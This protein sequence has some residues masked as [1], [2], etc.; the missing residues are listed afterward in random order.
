MEHI[1]N[2]GLFDLG[3]EMVATYY[4]LSERELDVV[5]LKIQG[6]SNKDIADNLFLALATVK[7]YVGQIYQ[8]LHVN[9]VRELKKK[10]EDL[11]LLNTE[12][13]VHTIPS[14]IPTHLTSFLGRETEIATV[15]EL[16]KEHRLVTLTGVGGT[17]KTRLVL[18]IAELVR[19]Q[20]R[21]DIAFV[22]LT[23]IHSHLDVP[24]AIADTLGLQSQDNDVEHTIITALSNRHMLL[25]LDNFEHV[26]AS[27]LL[28]S[29]LLQG[30]PRLS[31]LVTS[32][33]VL[34]LA[35]ECEYSVSPL[36]LP[37]LESPNRDNPTMELFE[38]RA[39]L[40]SNR[41]E[42]TEDNLST[43][44]EICHRLDGLPL[45]IELAAT[46][47]K[48][49]TPSVL[50][51]RLDNRLALL[52]DGNRD[53]SRRQQ[54]IR[55]SIEWS[56]DLLN[57]E[58]KKLFARLSVFRGGR[59]LDACE[60]VCADGLDI[61]VLSGIASLVDKSLLQQQTDALGEPRFIMLETIHEFASECLKNSDEAYNI[62]LRHAEYFRDVAL[63]ADPELRHA[64][65]VTWFARLE[66]EI[67]NFRKALE[68]CHENSEGIL[69]VILANG[70]QY[71]WTKRIYQ[72]EC[73]YRLQQSLKYLDDVPAQ[74]Q[75]KLLIG[76]GEMEGWLRLD[77][78][79]GRILAEQALNIAHELGDNYHLGLA[80]L[81]MVTTVHGI[82]RELE[83][84]IMPEETMTYCQNAMKIFVELNTLDKLA[85]AYN[86]LSNLYG[87]LGDKDKE[88]ESIEKCI[89]IAKRAGDLRRVY[90]N[91]NNL[92]DYHYQAGNYAVAKEISREATIL[93]RDA[94]DRFVLT[95]IAWNIFNLEAE[96]I[97]VTR[98]IAHV[99]TQFERLGTRGEPASDLEFYR[100]VEYLRSTVDK[101][102]FQ[103]AWDEGSQLTNDDAIAYA[104]GEIDPFND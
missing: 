63:Y 5:R 67:N 91:L 34:R 1:T 84:E 44:A 19:D 83:S 64:Q 92:A 61:D 62:H 6:V 47:L 33:E 23:Q 4:D 95:Y 25:I 104:L 79:K 35:G 36:P 42:L 27:A 81:G 28:V 69:L 80:Y 38:S 54:T 29:T 96:P 60:V 68:W 103:K 52:T 59:S 90:V 3:Y 14:T 99:K 16:T 32:R 57:V 66:I 58:E 49:L 50:L 86:M 76:V 94:N 17:G 97:P 87:R 74:E 100:R 102:T 70:L 30:A 82:S 41:F 71:F 72:F 40:A 51:K 37:D 65:Q 53:Q 22:D 89:E 73:D 7:W 48:L 9:N 101:D 75:I 13:R 26:I 56:Y 55:D 39:K 15:V 11:D 43:V 12:K 24:K 18:K 10:V 85:L 46:R 93:A 45:A 78:Q 31:I 77:F 98:L 88:I 8:K 2:I 21:D 20:Y